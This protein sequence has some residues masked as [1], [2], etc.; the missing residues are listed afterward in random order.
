MRKFR[1]NVFELDITWKCNLACANCTR[2]CDLLS[3]GPD[4]TPEFFEKQLYGTRHAWNAIY[5]MGGEPTLHPQLNEF[6]DIIAAYC[7]KNPKCQGTLVSNCHSEKTKAILY[8]ICF[9]T[10]N[11][12]VRHAAKNIATGVG[13]RPSRFWTV[14]IAPRDFPEFAE[15]DYARGCGQQMRCGLQLT[16]NGWYHCSM[17][18]GIDRVFGFGGDTLEGTLKNPRLGLFCQF[19]G[20]LRL[21]YAGVRYGTNEMHFSEANHLMFSESLKQYPLR[22]DKQFLSPSYAE[23]LKKGSIHA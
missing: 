8:D 11:I 5:I 21:S 17:A 20:R 2:R 23:A 13:A 3:P 22:S 18:G 16:I 4:M 14:N 12:Q 9:R 15:H 7:R 6:I 19:C 1:T 10:Q